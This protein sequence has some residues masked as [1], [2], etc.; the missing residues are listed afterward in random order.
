M[1]TVQRCVFSKCSADIVKLCRSNIFV[2]IIVCYYL[3]FVVAVDCIRCLLVSRVCP[4]SR[5][6]WKQRC[7]GCCSAHQG[8]PAFSIIEQC[9]CFVFRAM[10]AKELT[11]FALFR[12]LNK[13]HAMSKSWSS[14]KA[15]MWWRQAHTTLSR[16][17]PLWKFHSRRLTRMTDV[18]SHTLPTTAVLA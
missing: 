9:G 11:P 10:Y 13:F 17:C 15:L 8:F 14:P 1:F 5:G 16:A 7:S 12:A 6:S 2:I 4:C 3:L 18:C